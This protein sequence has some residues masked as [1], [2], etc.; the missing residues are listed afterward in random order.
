MP[1]ALQEILKHADIWQGN[2]RVKSGSC[3]SSFYPDFD[4]LLHDSGW[5]LNRLIEV[6]LEKENTLTIHRNIQILALE[7][8]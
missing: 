3:I 1:Q 8:Y 4:C 7:M 6:L 5:P 2:Q